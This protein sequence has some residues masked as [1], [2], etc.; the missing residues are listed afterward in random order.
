[1]KLYKEDKNQHTNYYSIA[2]LLNKRYKIWPLKYQNN[3][4]I[5]YKLDKFDNYYHTTYKFHPINNTHLDN[6]CTDLCQCLNRFCN[7][8]HKQCIDRCSDNDQQRNWGNL[9]KADHHNFHKRSHRKDIGCLQICNN[10][11]ILLKFFQYFINF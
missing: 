5:K 9:F 7:F 6:W 10:Q 1:L 4:L 3:K 11:S 2:G 8:S